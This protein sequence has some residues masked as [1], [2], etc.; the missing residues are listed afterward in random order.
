MDDSPGGKYNT[1]GSF[2]LIF[3]SNSPT[4]I[5]SEFLNEFCNVGEVYSKDKCL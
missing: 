4:N 1:F 2:L 5:N 3:G